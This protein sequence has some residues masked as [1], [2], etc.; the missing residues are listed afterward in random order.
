MRI[1]L[2][3]A[4]LFCPAILPF[5]ALAAQWGATLGTISGL[6]GLVGS[7]LQAGVASL[8][9]LEIAFSDASPEELLASGESLRTQTQGFS[10]SYTARTA[11]ALRSRAGAALQERGR[12]N[13]TGKPAEDTSTADP[14]TRMQRVDQIVGIATGMV[15]GL[16]TIT[17]AAWTP[18]CRA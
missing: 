4:S 13:R 14:P 18:A 2:F 1:H 11:G 12:V 5:V 7:L 6:V 8:R 9:A 16:A 10:A 3:V 17:P 15:A